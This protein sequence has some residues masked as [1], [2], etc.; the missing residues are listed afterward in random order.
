MRYIALMILILAMIM[1]CNSHDH[2]T[3][4]AEKSPHE[5]TAGEH[6]EE[7]PGH[8]DETPKKGEHEEA[9]DEHAEH[10]DEHGEHEEAE[11]GFVELTE[12]QKKEVGL[13]VAPP[14]TGQASGVVRTGR[15]ESDPDRRV[16][17]SP[18]VGGTIKHLPII[19]GSRVRQGDMLAVLDS[20]EVTV[21]KGEYHNAM[22]EVELATKELSNKEALF[23]IGDESRREVEEASL[24]L[25]EATANRD[26]AKARLE[27]AKLKHERLVKLRAEGIASSQQVEE[28]L[29]DR[30][31]LEADLREATSAVSIASQHLERERRVA[32]SDLR[33]KA[34]TFPA[35]AAL[36][37]AKES[38]KH[39]QER[40]I[41]LGA[42]LSEETGT[43]ALTSPI[44]GQVV[45]R[46][47]NR[48][49]AVSPGDPVAELV[50]PS[51]VWAIIDLTR[52]DLGTVNVGDAVT[53]TLVNDT[54]AKAVGEISNIDPQIDAESQTTRARVEL[55][56]VGG[57]FRVGSFINATILKEEDLPSLPDAAIQEVEGETVV[58]RVDG[59]GF[60]RTPVEIVGKSGQDV[61][62]SG[63]PEGSKVVIKG[64][65]D[66]KSLDLAGSIGGHHH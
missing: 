48:G 55:R 35:E 6:A 61:N 41:Q 24:Q 42:S 37:R 28:A 5:H 43:V 54:K 52:A 64:A 53:I 51:Q 58:Y 2:P 12:A 19:I 44:D 49:Q 23:A 46:P 3:A 65:G 16:L 34:E 18:Q 56:E 26:G 25:A 20:P 32:G 47:V 13:E 7:H 27:S 15:V 14:S 29:A 40:L 66:L 36:A 22:V 39:L 17:V 63:L 38:S 1:G 4:D 11:E 30:K 57:K 21:L 60:R 8:G 50:D 10:G 59:D 45:A 62:V 31:A 9:G 33:R